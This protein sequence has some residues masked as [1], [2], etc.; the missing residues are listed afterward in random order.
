MSL[1]DRVALITGG[2]GGIG[3]AIALALAREG[4]SI[5]VAGRH[6]EPLEKVAE[7]IEALGCKT[8]AAIMDVSQQDQVERTVREVVSEFGRLDILINTVAAPITWR[9]PFHET[10]REEWSDEISVTFVGTLLCCHAVIPH[11]IKQGYGRIIS[12]T[13]DSG[14]TGLAKGSLYS[15]CKAAI[16]GFSRAIALELA[17]SGITVNCVSPGPISTPRIAKIIAEHPEKKKEYA[18]LIP[19]ARIGEPEEV[20]SLVAYLASGNA[21][22]ITGQEYSVDGGRRM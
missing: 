13:S 10:I 19:M 22:Y 21:G 14:K 15:A 4:C 3:S 1:K 8:L 5:V 20:A 2:G 18:G 9:K 12:L 6:K 11:M 16:A 17:Q 7:E